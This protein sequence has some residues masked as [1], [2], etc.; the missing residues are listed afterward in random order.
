MENFRENVKQKYEEYVNL[1]G[2]RPRNVAAFV[3]HE[4][5]QDEQLFYTEFADFTTLEEEIFN[6]WALESLN[7]VRSEEVYSEYTVRE[8]LLSFYFTLLE[9]L[10]SHRSFV[11]VL[12]RLEHY[13]P[14]PTFMKRLAETFKHFVQELVLEGADTHEVEQRMFVSDRYPDMFVTQLRWILRYWV[15]DTS[16]SF[17][18]TDAFVEKAVN[19]TFDL[20][21]HNFIDS[22]I[23]FLRYAWQR[24]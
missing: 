5:L 10:K 9:V 15:R 23:D 21:S 14:S 1:H 22:G 20:V 18:D 16:P 8:K 3:H 4:L 6:D 2:K 11:K 13:R 7:K 12:Y 17:E 24:R 19:V